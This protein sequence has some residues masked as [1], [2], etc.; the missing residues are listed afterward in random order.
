MIIKEFISKYH[1]GGLTESAPV[2]I[3]K[4]KTTTF[5]L[6]D[7]SNVA[8]YIE[9]N[10]PIIEDL[11][12]EFV[13]Y[14]SST[15]LSILKKF[16]NPKMEVGHKQN[17]FNFKTPTHIKLNEGRISSQLV[18]AIPQV[19]VTPRTPKDTNPLFLINID[20]ELSAY[21]KN[22]SNILDSEHLS[23]Q[24]NKNGNIQIVFGVNEKALSDKIAYTTDTI[25]TS[26][27]KKQYFF[28]KPFVAILTENMN[29]GNTSIQLSVFQNHLEFLCKSD[30]YTATYYLK[31]KTH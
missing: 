3:F 19:G 8:G 17:A 22:F 29:G 25:Y 30:K 2:K 6:S 12:T 20:S 4:D 24:T 21:F 16:K 7:D 26:E 28:L 11:E 13:I 27:F 10:Q 15:A 18:V 23:F 9:Y 31:R 14:N 1:L 5:F